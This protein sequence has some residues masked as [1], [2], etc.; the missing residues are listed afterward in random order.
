LQKDL[1]NEAKELGF[2]E[3]FDLLKLHYG[4]ADI[5][6]RVHTHPAIDIDELLPPR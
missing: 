1:K 4:I 2:K 6:I 5:M 3:A